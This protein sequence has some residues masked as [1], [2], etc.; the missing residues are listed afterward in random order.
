MR[1]EA[2]LTAYWGLF[3]MAYVFCDYLNSSITTG[4]TQASW[5][6]VGT[7]LV[8]A[9]SWRRWIADSLFHFCYWRTLPLE[10]V[11]RRGKYRGAG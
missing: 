2:I 7:A 8:W 11:H 6:L 4:E 1:E 10:A 9:Q 5:T 3:V